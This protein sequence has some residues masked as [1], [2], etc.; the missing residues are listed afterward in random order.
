M[1]DPPTQVQARGL[2]VTSRVVDPETLLNTAL[3]IVVPAA[4]PCALPAV[5]IGATDEFEELQVTEDEMSWVVLSE[6]VPMAVNCSFPPIPTDEVEGV[7]VIE[8]N[9]LS[10]VSD[11]EED[12]QANRIIDSIV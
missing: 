4:C 2:L 3:I 7:T 11:V 9:L 8:I 5:S 10:V 1:S 12:L 6:Y